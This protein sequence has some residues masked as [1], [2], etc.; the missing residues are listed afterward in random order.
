MMISL[1]L[2]LVILGCSLC[3]SLFGIGLLFFG[4]PL[5]L[6][7]GYP[8]ETALSYLLPC[9]IIVNLLQVIH[10]RK[11]ISSFPLNILIYTLPFLIL[12]LFLVLQYDTHLQLK[13][14]IGSVLIFTGITRLFPKANQRTNQA[15]SYALKPALSLMGL[16]HGMTNMGGGLLAAIVSTLFSD[17]KAIRTLRQRRRACGLF[18]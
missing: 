18:P 17:K 12:G 6:L 11:E 5:L 13:P 2:P 4:T 16:I 14:L 3:Q 8:F 7:L 10:G 15:I 1:L 9:S